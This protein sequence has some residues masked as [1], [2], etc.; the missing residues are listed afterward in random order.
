MSD[1]QLQTILQPQGNSPVNRQLQRI[2]GSNPTSLLATLWVA[3]M[4]FWAVCGDLAASEIS[5]SSTSISLPSIANR[6][7]E[8]SKRIDYYLSGAQAKPYDANQ[9][10]ES[11]SLEFQAVSFSGAGFGSDTRLSESVAPGRFWQSNPATCV[12]NDGSIIVAFEDERQGSKKIF[13]QK[14]TSAGSPVGANVMIAGRV[15]GF[16]LVEPEIVATVSNKFY[17]GYRDV[18]SGQVRVARINSDLTIDLPDFSASDSS[19]S[20]Y[21][22]PFALAARTNGEFAIAYESYSNG[23]TI[24]LR[25]FTPAGTLASST[26]AVN[27]DGATVSHW[28]PDLAFDETGGIGVVWEDYRSGVADIFLRRFDSLGV[29][30]GSELNLIDADAQTQGQFLPSLVFS[31]ISGFVAGWSDS[32]DSWTVYIQRFSKQAGIGLVGAN[33]A[34]TPTDTL[35][36]YLDIDLAVSPVGI[37][38][39]AYC[40]YGASSEAM[41]QR[42][43]ASLTP[44]GTPLIL[45]SELFNQPVK[46][47]IAVGGNYA[48]VWE[49]ITNGDRDIRLTIANSNLTP[50]LAN[51]IL[52]HDDALGAVSDQPE[53]AV[54]G[55]RTVITVFRDL[56]RDAGDIYIQKNTLDGALVGANLLIN[57]D[58]SG[59]IQ[60]EPSISA[61]ADSYVVAWNDQRFI[62]GTTSAR[63]Y[64]RYGG[65]H[66]SSEILISGDSP[67]ASSATKATPSV[68]L[69][70]NGTALVAWLDMRNGSPQIFIR[71]LDSNR[72]PTGPEFQVSDDVQGG[73]NSKPTVTVDNG[74]V[75]VVAWKNTTGVGKPLINMRRYGSTGALLGSFSFVAD[76]TG[77]AIT[78]YDLDVDN[79]G[80]VFLLWSSASNTGGASLF[81][82]AFTN[83]GAKIGSS[84]EIP[85]NLNASPAEPSISVDEFGNIL[86]AWVD[87]RGPERRI[88]TQNFNSDMTPAGGNQP[89]SF[90]AAPAMFSPSTLAVGGRS[91][92]GWSD[93]RSEG[94]NVY[95]QGFVHFP[96]AVDDDNTAILPN[97]FAL[98]QNFPNPFNPTT[99]IAFTLPQRAN[100]TLTIYNV[101]GQ[102]IRELAQ[103]EF[104]AGKH[105]VLWDGANNNGASVASGIYFYRLKTDAFAETR[106][107]TLL[108]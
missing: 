55:A 39:A 9:V 1:E 34:I 26:S 22:G 90:A 46:P 84:M 5:P 16:D 81:L 70:P 103:G 60:S 72:T 27:T 91:W 40:A 77:A 73:G 102:E 29:A 80:K 49:L 67:G 44:V 38:S 74:N 98:E 31:N 50:M 13:L 68:A 89:L 93:A 106:K 71:L 10:I 105:Q 3:I 96:T 82:T 59:G 66:A 86:M 108:K 87:S 35:T 6:V 21:A 107:M 100:L 20:V 76:Q 33:R 48:L 88:Y 12:L 11:G 79:S 95:V 23:N 104:P 65:A 47:A 32:R 28:T 99:H 56:R 18:A 2:W 24:A 37:V 52:A 78:D 30:L 61:N 19:A 83:G 7:I 42:F 64:L 97:Q 45:A 69:A 43:D 15:D 57:E 63:I 54:I 85:D 4:L 92:V 62:S 36:S 94:M 25:R 101:L 17:L 58:N 53:V 8:H 75:F 14:Y 51:P 41:A